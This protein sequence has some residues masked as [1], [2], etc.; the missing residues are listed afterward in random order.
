VVGGWWLVT[1]VDASLFRHSAM[2]A[3]EELVGGMAAAN[4]PF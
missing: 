1:G 4:V 3:R 2:A